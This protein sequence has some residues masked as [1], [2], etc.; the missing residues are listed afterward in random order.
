MTTRLPGIY[1]ENAV[2]P[3]SDT[4]PRMD[5]A[6]F[7]GFA[8]SGPL[9]TPVPIKDPSRFQEIFGQDQ[10]L[11]WDPV[12]G[13]T[14][15]AQLA[16]T[17]RAF[18]RNGGLRCWVVRVA[19]HPPLDDNQIPVVGRAASNQFLLPGTL[20]AN[21]D[22]PLEAAWLSAR[23]EGSWSDDY[24]ANAT[25]SISP[26]EAEQPQFSSSGI[27]VVLYPNAL[28]S[29][30]VGDLLQ[31]SFDVEAGSPSSSNKPLLFL[32]VT[33]V[34]TAVEPTSEGGLQQT[35]TV[36][37]SNGYW[38]QPAGIEDFLH[39]QSSPPPGQENSPTTWLVAPQRVFWLTQPQDNELWSG[40]WGVEQSNGTAT[41]VVDTLR[42]DTDNIT[43][44]TWLR[45][46]LQ[47]AGPHGAKE[48]LLL[49]DSV[50]GSQILGPAQQ[51]SPTGGQ[52]ETAQVV[53][54]LG[55]WVVDDQVGRNLGL[56]SARVDVLTL[57]L[58]VRDGSG[59]ITTLSN[60][61]L[62]PSNPR[63]I[64][65][66]PA[67]AQLYAPTDSSSAPTWDGFANE[68]DHPR[69]ALA[70]PSNATN[71]P[72]YLPLGVPGLVDA[73][74]Y[75]PALIQPGRPLERDGLALADGQ[76]SASLFLDPD[77]ETATVA[78]LLTEAFHKQYQL[79]RGD[80]QNPGEP[81][82]K[83]HSLL[84]IDEISMLALPDAMHPGWQLASAQPGQN[85]GAP[86][87]LSLVAAS[88]SGQITASWTAVPGATSYTL[89]QSTDPQ[90]ASS[91]VVFSGPGTPGAS[92]SGLTTSVPFPGASGCPVPDYFRVC[93]VQGVISG[94]WSN[95]ISRTLP[96]EPFT[97]CRETTLDPPLLAA[98][99][100][101]R[102]R[103]VL[104]WS[105]T[106]T[107]VERFTL[108]VAYEPAFLLPEFLYQ[109]SDS[110]FEIWSDPT[111]TAYFRVC[112]IRGSQTGPW[113]NTVVVQ[114]DFASQQY[115]MNLPPPPGSP[116]ISFTELLQVHEAMIRLCAARADVFALLSLPRN[117]DAAT[118]VLYKALLTQALAPE[119]GDTTLSFAAIYFP[120]LVTRDLSSQQPGAIRAVAP[121][122]AIA[123]VLAANTLSA[124]AWLSPANQVFTGTVDIDEQLGDQ[125]ATAF[126]SN[127]LNL[128][129]QA[130]P[131]FLTM[132]SQ[133]LS[134]WSQ[135]A[136][137]N[138][139]RLLILL[140]RIALREGVDYVFQ[141]ND[142]TF[143]RRVKRRFDDLLSKM[144]VQGA[145]AGASQD[146]GFV[147]RTDDSVNTPAT[148]QQGQFVVEINVAPSLP[149]EFLTMR[150]VQQGENVTLTETF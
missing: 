100:E 140:R 138:V 106:Q 53:A 150:L 41:F 110:Y 148:I 108:Q 126:F 37:G 31:I 57:E 105:L 79:Q 18:F 40:A 66:L 38:F 124:G 44:G 62:V 65:V 142:T 27:S 29:V 28:T 134:P 114:S 26:I 75:Q 121:E 46:E 68:I 116:E 78:T 122:G 104:Q 25:L 30:S 23:S 67:D 107:D 102:G 146:Q 71:S 99:S 39:L 2:P 4:L 5:I 84:P 13:E 55:W 61:G 96:V 58:W 149:L 97:A 54:S 147:V 93:A 137:M 70:A 21:P 1:F 76:L 34:A 20:V 98:P 22:S 42:S 112:A 69:F 14:V 139:R 10:V 60:I 49:V 111:R 144:Y 101:S 118:C 115:W 125:A 85:L 77:L 113:S 8:S 35:I 32:P 48:L 136:E 91:T 80:A 129:Y 89:E 82:L 33:G 119:D 128:V 15:Y 127:Q 7:V 36:S 90:F 50:R 95:T 9:D 56:S 59:K 6:G 47:Q 130:S 94:P 83:M 135:L 74:F 133:T 120:W 132:S 72:V 92:N 143:W 88:S 103:V 51:G 131:G 141:P 63:Y 16:P 87:L 109:G 43:S 19:N 64:G 3:V 52:Q 73:D 86:T 81:L 123:G 17:V 11:A 24:N 45:V 145:F 117:Y 12:A